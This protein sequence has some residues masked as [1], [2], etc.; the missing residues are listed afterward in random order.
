MPTEASEKNNRTVIGL[1]QQNNRAD[2]GVPN[3]GQTMALTAA[4]GPERSDGDEVL[5]K[6]P[7]PARSFRTS[8]STSERAVRCRGAQHCACE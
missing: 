7:I 1:P 6:C 4:H 3:H 8:D 5:Q 2:T